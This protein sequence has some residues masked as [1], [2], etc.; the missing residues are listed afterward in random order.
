MKKTLIIFVVCIFFYSSFTDKLSAQDSLKN[1]QVNKQISIPEKDA[2]MIIS[3]SKALSRLQLGGYGEIAMSRN[4]YSDNINRYSH[5]SDY[6]DAKSH[7]RFDIPH[8]TFFIGYD[9][10]KGWRMNAEIEF[11]HGGTE[12]AIELEAEEAGEYES[13]IERGGEVAL[14]QFWIEKTITP[15]LNIRIGHFV[16]PVGYTNANHLPTQFFTVYRP[17]GENTIMP[18][19]WH[20]TGIS[21]WGNIGKWRYEAQ[22]IPGLDSELF[23]RKGWIQGGSASPYE[24]K[25][26]N[27]YAGVL[28]IDNYSVR[29]LR[30]GVSGYYGHSFN[31]NMQPTDAVKY[32]KIKGAVTIGTF[33][34]EYKGYNIIAR[35]YFDY[36]HLGDSETIS[37][38]NKSRSKN[39]PSP[40]TNVASDAI[41]IGFEAGYDIFSHINK[42]KQDNQK[43]Y[44]FG[45]YEYYDSMYKTATNVTES[46][47][48][49]RQR[50]VG[51][52]NYFP[53]KQVVIKAEYSAGLLKSQF[54]NENSLS[55][56]IAYAGL[57]TR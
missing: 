27:K 9:F 24:F 50:I 53:L 10:G 48:C 37:Q 42:L 41:A 14:E 39:S 51:G 17:E 19:T 56:G 29:G 46:E 3:L 18:C 22:F 13:E 12:A 36:G 26:A 15:A 30:M 16:V 23:D 45:R 35:G 32:E 44:V 21:L 6:K 5:A 55:I 49:G 47:W 52:L 54:N 31:N 4:F 57:F 2:D 38:F 11:E 7:G 43:L 8:V 28:R 33:D 25:I 20:E 40:R 34:F 1:E